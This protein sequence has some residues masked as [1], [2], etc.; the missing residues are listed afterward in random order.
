MNYKII[1]LLIFIIP[2]SITA[3]NNMQQALKKGGWTGGLAGWVGWE[4][5]KTSDNNS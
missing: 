2:I 3:Q 4:N 1:L 5:F